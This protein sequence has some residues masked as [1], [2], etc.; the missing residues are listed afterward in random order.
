MSRLFQIQQEILNHFLNGSKDYKFLDS[1]TLEELDIYKSL[2][3]NSAEK[4]LASGFEHS[5]KLLKPQ[6][7]EIINF[8]L[9]NFPSHS[10]I[11]F[12]IG[13]NFPEFIKSELFKKNFSYPGYLWELAELEWTKI[14]LLNSNQDQK[15]QSSILNPVYKI[16]SFNYPIT[17]IIAYLADED[18]SLEDKITTEIETDSENL[19]IYRDSES[20]QI[21]TFLLSESVI[22]V[23]KYLEQGLSPEE[24]TGLL[25][26]TENSGQISQIQKELFYLLE[27]LKKLNILIKY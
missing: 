21:K 19:F 27:N 5:Y 1:N 12:M 16:L 11:Y 3:L 7:R 23:I 4:F 15:N 14:E 2:V 26:N 18:I 24:I 13:K 6:W 9:E 20:L 8:Y 10:P 17:Q 25:C 22:E